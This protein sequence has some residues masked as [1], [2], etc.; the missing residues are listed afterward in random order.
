MRY[1]QEQHLMG[2]SSVETLDRGLFSPCPYLL[3]VCGQRFPQNG[4]SGAHRTVSWANI[5]TTLKIFQQQLVFT[6]ESDKDVQS[7]VK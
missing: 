2:Q 3:R 4:L 7:M 1:E 5:F 6:L